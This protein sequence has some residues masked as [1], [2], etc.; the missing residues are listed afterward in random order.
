MSAA[1]QQ[2]IALAAVL[3]AGAYVARRA[4]QGW[5]ASRAASAVRDAGCGPSCGCH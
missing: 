1:A 4:W 2:V 3:I 5:R